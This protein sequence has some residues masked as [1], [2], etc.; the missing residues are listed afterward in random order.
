M[1][2]PWQVKNG[3]KY[4]WILAIPVVLSGTAFAATTHKSHGQSSPPAV[5]KMGTTCIFTAGPKAGTT[6][7]Y[8]PMQMPVDTPCND[9]SGST[10]VI[11]PMATTQQLG[12][13]CKFA[14]G[15]KA[16]T[17]H[18]YAPMH[19]PLNTPCELK[20]CAAVL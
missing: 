6:R 5:Q 11:L 15:P 1:T 19:A 12:T 7:D 2:R 18:D 3:S 17:T 8:A 13:I 10:G 9:G 16:G 20:W 14:A 4:A